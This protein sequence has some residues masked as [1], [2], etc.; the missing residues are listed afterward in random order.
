[1]VVIFVAC[2]QH[3]VC[4]PRITKL[5]QGVEV[6][7]HY[8]MEDEKK[9]FVANESLFNASK[10]RSYTVIYKYNFFPFLTHFFLYIPLLTLLIFGASVLSYPLLIDVIALGN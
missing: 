10:A 1:M 4:K 9:F 3:Q 8:P 6:R 5:G 2:L 7:A